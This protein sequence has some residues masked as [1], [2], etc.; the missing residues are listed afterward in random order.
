MSIDFKNINKS[1]ESGKMILNDLSFSLP[2]GKFSGL[3]GPSGCGKTTL[4]RII[5]GLDAPNS[6]K[7]QIGSDVFVDS[8]KKFF[9][10]PEKRNVGMVFQSYAVWPH[11]NVFENIAFPLRIRKLSKE[12]IH[13]EVSKA[14]K[15]V[16]LDGLEKRAPSALSGGQQQRVALARALVQKPRLLLLDEPLSNLDASLRESMRSE[17]R[18]LQVDLG[19]TAI[20][21]T[22]DWADA[23]NLC[24]S[25]VVMSEGKIV[26]QSSPVDLAANPAS[27]FV[28]RLIQA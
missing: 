4:L 11:M 10:E 22:H 7:I 17:I 23:R 13:D 12:R 24:D 20:I 26:Q 6:G 14:I 16:R 27:P 21:V 5:A 2:S 15:T 28:S 3:L 1:F 18:Q 9:L 25:I 8:E 19:L